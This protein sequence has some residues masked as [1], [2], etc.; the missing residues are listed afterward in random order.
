MVSLTE[1]CRVT[2][3]SGRTLQYAFR[4]V[5]GLSPTVYLRLRALHWVHAEL[6]D[7]SPGETTVTDVA[8]RWGFW[9]LGRF[10]ASYRA[11]FGTSPS[12]ELRGFSRETA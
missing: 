7:A 2:G 5:T 9:H 8:M 11:T 1:L 6:R 3:S 10:A 4:E 12:Q